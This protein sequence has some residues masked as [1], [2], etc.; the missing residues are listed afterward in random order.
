MSV[1]YYQSKSSR[2]YKGEFVTATLGK[3]P[4]YLSTGECVNK[5]LPSYNRIPISNEKEWTADVDKPDALTLVKEEIPNGYILYDSIYMPFWKRQ[6]Y[7]DRKQITDGEGVEKR[8]PQN[9]AQ[10][11]WRCD[12]TVLCLDCSIGYRSVGIFVETLQNAMP[13]N[14]HFTTCK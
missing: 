10:G 14:I 9:T 5:Q 1:K 2:N 13:Q 3:K 8:W 4:T 6:D 11:I 12:G 7:G